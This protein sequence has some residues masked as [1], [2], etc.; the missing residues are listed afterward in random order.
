MQ[1]DCVQ[2]FLFE[3]L[4]IRGALVTLDKTWRDLAAGRDYPANVTRILG[5]MSAVTTLIA[6]NLKQAGRMTFQLRGAGPINLLVLDCDGGNDAQ[7]QIRGMARW[8]AQTLRQ[9][10]ALPALLGDGQLLLTLDAVA[11]RQPYQSF[12]PMQGDSVAAIFEHYLTLSEQQ[13]TRLI[14]AANATRAVGLLLQ[15][16]PDTELPDSA[17]HDADG[18]NR[19]QHLLGTLQAD[20]QL[21][22]PPLDLLR[23]L[24]PAEDVRVFAPRPVSHHCPQDWEK[25]HAMLRSLGRAECDAMLHDESEGH[26]GE[27]HV[28]DDIC[29][30]DYWIDA[31]DLDAIFAAPAHRMH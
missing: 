13:P 3:H 1:T 12:V 31:A 28:R 17:Q 11:M 21:A 15:K 18:W 24:F 6:A 7:L 16:M 25:I 2:P 19:I 9:D 29:N 4:A 30:H 27:I 5:E 10:A 22:Q 26:A 23:R 20:E 14:L 8:D